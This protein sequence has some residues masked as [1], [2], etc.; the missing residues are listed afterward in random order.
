MLTRQN[1][2]AVLRAPKKGTEKFGGTT[3][4]NCDPLTVLSF[5]VNAGYTLHFH[6]EAPR[7]V[8]MQFK[9]EISQHP[10]SSLWLAYMY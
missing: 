1:K 4:V 10:I 7:P 9:A 3:L 6:A 5:S 8:S 2:N